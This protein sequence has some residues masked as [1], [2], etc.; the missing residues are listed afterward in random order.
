VIIN[1]RIHQVQVNF[2][3]KEEEAKLIPCPMCTK[4]LPPHK[5]ERHI[6]NHRQVK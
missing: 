1:K 5:I 4:W 2:D 6:S 3:F